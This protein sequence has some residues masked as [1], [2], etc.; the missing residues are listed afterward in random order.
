MIKNI[1][2]LSSNNTGHGHKSITDSLLEQFS[3][4]PDVKVHVVDGF[5]LAGNFGLRVG[6]LYG[7]VT[8]NA[9]DL[10]KLVWEISLKKP[11]LLN[12]FTEVSIKDNFLKLIHDIKPDLILS[13]HPNFNGSVLNILEDYNINIP[14]VTLIAD[15]VSIT[16]L[17]ADPRVDYIICP[18]KES[19]FKCLEFGVSE[20]KLIETG[21]PVRQ[22]FLKHINDNSGDYD[23]NT[24]KYTG[25]RPFECLIMSGGEGSGN[26]SRI[27]SILLKN[28][29]CRVKIVT[30][31]NKLLKKRLER[32]IGEQYGDRVEI[33]GFTENIQD[34][35]LSSDIAVT[36]GSPNVMMEAVA[37]NVPIIITGNLPG[38]EEGNPA[39]MQKYNLGIVCKDLRKLRHTV[40]GLLANNAEKLNKIK[41]SQKE[42]LNPNVAKEIVSFL[43]SIEKKG[44]TNFPDDLFSDDFPKFWEIHKKISLSHNKKIVLKKHKNIKINQK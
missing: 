43:L 36:R 35:M 22:K 31:R 3:L 16:P 24:R 44:D 21:F 42:Y 2:I 30:G 34:L 17:W 37:C 14:I 26:M 19:K 6:K 29:N 40:D 8:R 20:S 4:Y 27:A 5:T 10:W 41:Q 12:D 18:S 7:S 28:F 25:D 13:V 9:K 23:Q 11:S 15:I 39:Y 38:Q 1:L 33:Y 32:T